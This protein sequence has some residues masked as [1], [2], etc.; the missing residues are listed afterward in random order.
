MRCGF[1]T[2][3]GLVESSEESQWELFS[4]VDNTQRGSQQRMIE[5]LRYIGER[6][7]KQ[8]AGESETISCKILGVIS[9]ER[10]VFMCKY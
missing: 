2:H 4:L 1:L 5:K 8:S 7:Y 10:T 6:Y 3:S 9:H